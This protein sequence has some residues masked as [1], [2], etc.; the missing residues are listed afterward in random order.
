MRLSHF[1]H[2]VARHIDEVSVN[3]APDAPADARFGWADAG[4]GRDI[5]SLIR[6]M[7]HCGAIRS[8]QR[9]AGKRRWHVFDYP[10]VG[11]RQGRWRRINGS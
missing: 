3:A 1:R 4:D 5:H 10:V 11:G 7:L 9:G 8:L 2:N 6:L